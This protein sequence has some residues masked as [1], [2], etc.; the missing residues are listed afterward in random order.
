MKPEV[1]ID[2]QLAQDRPGQVRRGFTAKVAASN[3]AGHREVV[4][5][6]GA[7]LVA[8]ARGDQC[9]AVDGGDQRDERSAQGASPG[10]ATV[11]LGGVP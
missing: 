5:G 10:G 9:P 2:W 8:E 11:L 3:F 4:V 1:V 7:R 6:I